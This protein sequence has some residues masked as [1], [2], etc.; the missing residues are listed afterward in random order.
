MWGSCTY[1][2]KFDFLLLICLMSIEFL[3]TQKNLE[4]ERKIFFLPD[5]T[6]HKDY[7]HPQ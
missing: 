4:G 7:N 1:E 5:N 2:N 6:H 3:T